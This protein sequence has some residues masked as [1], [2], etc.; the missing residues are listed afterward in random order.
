MV[1]APTNNSARASAVSF[2]SGICVLAQPNILASAIR[3]GASRPMYVSQ[4]RRAPADARNR[5]RSSEGVE[6]VA[7]RA[8]R[9][10]RPLPAGAGGLATLRA[11]LVSRLEAELAHVVFTTHTP[12]PPASPPVRPRARNAAAGATAGA[13]T[14]PTAAAPPR[15][16]V[17]STPDVSTPAAGSL[18]QQAADRKVS[19]YDPAPRRSPLLTPSRDPSKIRT[20]F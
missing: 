14:E 5:S 18:R 17:G 1:T 7:M 16:S 11:G 19:S 15:S 13:G 4:S 10:S 2:G 8:P 6:R 12:V 9:R 3:H 20:I